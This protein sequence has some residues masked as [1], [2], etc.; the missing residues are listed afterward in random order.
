MYKCTLDLGP[1]INIHLNISSEELCRFLET[2]RQNEWHFSLF[3]QV[4]WFAIKG[5][6]KDLSRAHILHAS[7]FQLA[8]NF[9]G[10]TY[11]Y[12]G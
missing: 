6:R 1:E 10:C 8:F 3:L 12:L 11:K 5:E 4:L 2:T 7:I 9:Q